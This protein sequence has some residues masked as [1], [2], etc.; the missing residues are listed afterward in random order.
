MFL[1][2]KKTLESVPVNAINKNMETPTTLKIPKLEFR[3]PRRNLPRRTSRKNTERNFTIN[4]ARA[5][6]SRIDSLH[7]GTTRTEAFFSREIP[8]NG[9]GIADFIAIFFDP[10]K[11]K[12][13]KHI[14]NAADFSQI[15]KPVIRAFEVKISNWRKALMQAY[16]YRYFA[17][18]SIVVL[19]S[20]KL[21]TA[22]RYVNTF[23]AIK[24]GLWGFSDNT[25]QVIPLF[26]P[27][28]TKPLEPR[29]K[30]HVIQMIAKAS[31]FQQLV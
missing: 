21:K 28:P 15:T 10:Q 23:K 27:R 16:R 7:Q 26:T 4:F 5:Y 29:H 20:E 22:A 12:D 30:P 11:F 25:S 3:E 13:N 18:V 19:P 8:V 31:R 9:F 1:I 6:A 24:V 2:E 17:D 14:S